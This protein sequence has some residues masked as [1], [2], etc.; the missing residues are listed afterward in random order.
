MYATTRI[1][2]NRFDLFSVVVG[3]LRRLIYLGFDASAV[4]G[5]DGLS[6]AS[7]HKCSQILC[8]TQY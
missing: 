1:L 2:G 3:G 6:A 4:L 8:G 5:G 7:A